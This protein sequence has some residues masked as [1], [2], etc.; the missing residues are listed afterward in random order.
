MLLQNREYVFVED[1]RRLGRRLGGDEHAHAQ[2]N[3]NSDH[4]N[5][6]NLNALDVTCRLRDTTGKEH[7][8]YVVFHWEPVLELR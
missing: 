3:W 8:I 5:L 7:H 4:G 1:R 6:T 2:R